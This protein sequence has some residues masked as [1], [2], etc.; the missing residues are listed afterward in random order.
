[1]AG[2]SVVGPDLPHTGASDTGASDTGAPDTSAPDTGA[3]AQL[4]LLA[5]LAPAGLDLVAARAKVDAVASGRRRGRRI[6]AGSCAAVL[7]IAGC[8]AV[9]LLGANDPDDIV[10]DG[11][12]TE[13]STT[14]STSTTLPDA[15][16]RVTASS[17]PTAPTVAPVVPTTTVASSTTVP[18]TA[19]PPTTLPPPPPNQALEAQLT[20]LS[21]NPEAGDLAEIDLVWRDADH[22][23]TA[24][25]LAID[26]GDPAV[27]VV[28]AV[29][30][31][32]PCDAPGPP[33]GGTERLGF[34]YATPGEHEVSVV[35]STCDGVGPYAERVRLTTKIVVREPAG[36]AERA[37]VAVVPRQV[38]IDEPPLDDA[39]AELLVDGAAALPLAARRPALQQV[40]AAGSATVL[41]V[42]VGAVGTLRLTWAVAPC[43]ASGPIDL[44]SAAP[45]VAPQVVVRPGC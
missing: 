17:V 19:A 8:V 25:H 20:L 44:A 18:V 12:R 14:T 36:G 21:P 13:R 45:G 33:A 10:A 38:G 32:G 30:A 43:P 26:W 35:V 31:G 1:M 41:R 3:T 39:A 6:L 27:S 29:P 9:A 42:P 4:E 23:G 24:P 16:A 28:R 37:V 22:S 40:T 5:P 7:V 15:D 11:D 2:T 34:R